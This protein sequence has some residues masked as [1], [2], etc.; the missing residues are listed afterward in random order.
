MAFLITLRIK[1]ERWKNRSYTD[2]NASIVAFFCDDI[3]WN[4]NIS[5]SHSD[6]FGVLEM[7][8]LIECIM[9]G[10]EK[11]I[12][13]F[14]NERSRAEKI[15]FYCMY[16][17]DSK[18]SFAMSVESVRQTKRKLDKTVSCLKCGKDFS[19]RSNVR[20]CRGCRESNSK[21]SDDIIGAG[22]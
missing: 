7:T 12:R 8:L 13:S 2:A 20:T 18:K 5:R 19:G 9:C 10:N 16:Q 15:C 17:R 1:N 14:T 22:L 11:H 21:Y 3:Y 4:T 6:G